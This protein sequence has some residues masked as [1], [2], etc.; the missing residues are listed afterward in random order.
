MEC[1]DYG[2]IVKKYYETFPRKSLCRLP[3]FISRILCPNEKTCSTATTTAR[4]R[5]NTKSAHTASSAGSTRPGCSVFGGGTATAT[6]GQAGTIATATARA[7]RQ[8]KGEIVGER[9][10]SSTC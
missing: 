8:E 7:A 9:L 6:T 1:Q 2:I 3:L 4:A 5:R 10:P